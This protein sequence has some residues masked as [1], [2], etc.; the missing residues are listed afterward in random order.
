MFCV[1]SVTQSE[2]MASHVEKFTEGGGASVLYQCTKEELTS[3]VKY[4]DVSLK[5]ILKG[6]MQEELVE[7][8]AEKIFYV[9]LS[10]MKM[11]MMEGR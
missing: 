9:K 6:G 4:Y 7:A 2:T 3:I 1:V 8:L 10:K 5:T 11:K